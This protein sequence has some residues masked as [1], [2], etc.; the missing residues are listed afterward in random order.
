[1]YLCGSI[2]YPSVKLNNYIIGISYLY[3]ISIAIASIAIM[4]NQL[5]QYQATTV[6]SF[7][8]WYSS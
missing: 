1:M 4:S 7:D 2:A 3:Y 5:V 8:T 6:P